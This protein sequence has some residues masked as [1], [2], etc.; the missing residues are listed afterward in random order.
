MLTE[1]LQ[2]LVSPEQKQRLE[3]EARARGESVGGLVRD[4]IDEQYGGRRF[5][6]SDEERTAALE[7]TRSA[8]TI[9]FIAPDALDR[10]AGREIEDEHPEL[11]PGRAR[12]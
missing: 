2:I 5:T 4:A 1:R 3:A 12:Q 8:S 11:F 6:F 10:I 7:R 9:P